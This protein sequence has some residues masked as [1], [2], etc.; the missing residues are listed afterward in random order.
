MSEAVVANSKRHILTVGLDDYYHAEVRDL[1]GHTARMH[2]ETQDK[3]DVTQETPE[4]EVELEHLE[5]AHSSKAESEAIQY[6]C[7]DCG[8][9]FGGKPDTCPKCGANLDWE[10]V[11]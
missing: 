1:K 6:H 3:P 4:S 2:P 11:N 5:I 9:R 7:V 8:E 10:A